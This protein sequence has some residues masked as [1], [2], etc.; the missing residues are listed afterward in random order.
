MG[1]FGTHVAPQRGDGVMAMRLIRSL[2]ILSLVVVALVQSSGHVRTEGDATTA[3]L[4]MIDRGGAA[5]YSPSY[6]SGGWDRIV[7]LRIGWGQA[8]DDFVYRTDGHWC[9]HPDYTFGNVLTLR[10]PRTGL[11][12]TCTIGDTVAPRDQAHWRAHVVIEIAWALFRDLGLDE[13][14]DVQVWVLQ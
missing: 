1:L 5:Y 2:V 10:N 7:N 14:N 9:V 3:G 4:A 8:G 12:M 6:D 13:G 11:V